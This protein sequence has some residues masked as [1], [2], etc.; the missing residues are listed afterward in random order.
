[1]STMHFNT[2]QVHGNHLFLLL[3]VIPEI[4]RS[5]M[6]ILQWNKK[7]FVLLYLLYLD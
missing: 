7:D 3:T 4:I 1:M 6:V 2:K 5:N